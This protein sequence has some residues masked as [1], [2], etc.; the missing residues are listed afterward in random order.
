M[1]AIEKNKDLKI[2]KKCKFI[3]EFT[4]IN[5]MKYVYFSKAITHWTLQNLYCRFRKNAMK[6]EAAGIF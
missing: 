1:H 6:S 3:S 2:A 4:L 5:I